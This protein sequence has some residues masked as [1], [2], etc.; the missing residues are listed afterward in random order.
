MTAKNTE[1]QTEK[2][3]GL[4][5]S[6]GLWSTIIVRYG[7]NFVRLRLPDPHPT[8]VRRVLGKSLRQLDRA[9]RPSRKPVKPA[10]R[11]RA[12]LLEKAKKARP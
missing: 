4:V 12:A 5:Q 3:N 7:D 2:H 9:L 6:L 1:N 8:A 10:P 11:R